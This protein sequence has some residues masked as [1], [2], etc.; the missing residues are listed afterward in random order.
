MGGQESRVAF[1]ET[2]VGLL[3]ETKVMLVVALWLWLLLVACE[4]VSS[5][6]VQETRESNERNLRETRESSERNL[7]ETRESNERIFK[8]SIAE[9]K[10]LCAA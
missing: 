6:A 9:A 4:R 10:V 8:A 3:A 7:T 5:S 2:V 1:Q